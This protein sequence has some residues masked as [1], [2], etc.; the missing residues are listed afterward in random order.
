[1]NIL[2]FAI[3][4]E[5]EGETFYRS[6]AK[7]N[8]D[9]ALVTVFLA[10]AEDEKHH[11]RIVTEFLKDDRIVL[12]NGDLPKSSG[13]FKEHFVNDIKQMPEQLD[14][15]REAL[16]KEQESIALYKKL[17]E[18]AKN[19]IEKNMFGYLIEQEESH[20]STIENIIFHLEKAESWVESAEFGVREDY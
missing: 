1:M 18:D 4:M 20:F 10:L 13:V 3:N 11:A 2:E 17:M 7:G 5:K 19:L 15:Y 14:A 6:L 9:N 8:N 12:P 16:K